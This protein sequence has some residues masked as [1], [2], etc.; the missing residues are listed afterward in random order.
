[1]E[2]PYGSF[3]QRQRKEERARQKE[4]R[5]GQPAAEPSRPV[6]EYE[7]FELLGMAPGCTPEGLADAYHRTVSQ[8]HPDKLET[9][10]PELRD[11]ATRRM[12]RI[13]EAYQR[14]KSRAARHH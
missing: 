7:A 9:M 5:A 11:Y 1:M 10:V 6:T 13:N 3:R 12:A 14:L 4:G 2:M 8:W